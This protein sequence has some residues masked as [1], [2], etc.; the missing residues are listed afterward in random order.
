MLALQ[1]QHVLW[2][3]CA[4]NVL[5]SS[6]ADNSIFVWD[7]GS[8]EI[9]VQIKDVHPDMIFSMSWNYDGSLLAT[10]CKDKKIRVLD[11]RTG[12]VIAVSGDVC[13]CDVCGCD[14]WV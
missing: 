11:P 7:T 10:T 13:G 1:V 14:V 6:S 9:L 8:G 2:H 12:D 4:E 5:A 3:P